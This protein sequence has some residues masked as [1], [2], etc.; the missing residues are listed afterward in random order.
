[1]YANREPEPKET[2]MADPVNARL[3][4]VTPTD[5]PGVK[6]ANVGNSATK[7]G[8][9]SEFSRVLD[10]QRA[11]DRD[12]ARSTAESSSGTDSSGKA[13][14]PEGNE[15]ADSPSS[16]SAVAADNAAVANDDGPAEADVDTSAGQNTP[17]GDEPA[18]QGTGQFSSSL[19]DSLARESRLLPSGDA[20]AG[21]LPEAR[22]SSLNPAPVL[23]GDALP[24]NA[25]A[26]AGVASAAKSASTNSDVSSAIQSGPVQTATTALSSPTNAPLSGLGNLSGSTPDI[27]SSAA[28]AALLTPALKDSDALA[29]SPA[30]GDTLSRAVGANGANAGERSTLSQ[31]DSGTLNR[32]TAD[33]L[34]S[35]MGS[36]AA[37]QRGLADMQLD[38]TADLARGLLSSQRADGSAPVL[39]ASTAAGL[40]PASSVAGSTLPAATATTGAMAE[41]SL[42]RAPDDTEFPGELTARMRTL[43]RDGVHEARLNLH[44][45]EL[46]RLQVTVTTEG[47]LTKVAFTTETLAARDAIEQS[48]P[49]L[50][51]MLEQSGLQLAQSDVGQ[52]DLQGNGERGG[53]EQFA[54]QQGASEDADA[55]APVLVTAHPANSRIDTYI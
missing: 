14:P 47:D 35:G 30:L 9:N 15:T 45:A 10:T 43:V 33:W 23:P 38:S 39:A 52:R 22:P 28:A 6:S 19:D 2:V 37:G 46:G 29:R 41:Y 12:S 18:E 44:P 5:S 27:V 4:S 7:S 53:D 17:A 25:L 20:Q 48:M 51:E 1:M 32:S 3:L 21:A 11:R 34:G 16:G 50:R 42:A 13:L 54:A 40:T 24:K 8:E 31:I 55:D 36:E 49:R 26:A